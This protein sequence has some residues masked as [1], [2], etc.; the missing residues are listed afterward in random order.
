MSYLFVLLSS[1]FFLLSPFFFHIYVLFVLLS[2]FFFLRS[3][4]TFLLSSSFVRRSSFFVRAHEIRPIAGLSVNKSNT[5]PDKRSSGRYVNVQMDV[6]LSSFFVRAARGS[7]SRFGTSLV[8][9]LL[10]GCFSVGASCWVWCFVRC[11]FLRFNTTSRSMRLWKT[12]ICVKRNTDLVWAK[13]TCFFCSLGLLCLKKK[14]MANVS[15][16][17]DFGG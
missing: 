2:S 13:R 8:S 3:S 17:L 15:N 4:F 12:A 11:D 16:N 14:G 1:F 6:D 10:F 5:T 9:Y 7:I